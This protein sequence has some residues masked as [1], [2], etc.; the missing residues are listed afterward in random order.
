[1]P[2]HLRFEKIAERHR[3]TTK[4]RRPAS[5]HWRGRAVDGERKRHVS[6]VRHPVVPEEVAPFLAQAGQVLLD[7]G[8]APSAIQLELANAERFLMARV[9]KP[10]A[11]TVAPSV[12]DAEPVPQPSRRGRPRNRKSQKLARLIVDNLG[13]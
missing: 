13:H 6:N 3:L 2:L 7:M 1:M 11:P 12:P 8:A 4:K 10:K 5:V 9:A